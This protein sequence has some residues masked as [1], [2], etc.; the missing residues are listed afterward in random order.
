MKWLNAAPIA[1]NPYSPDILERRL[2]ETHNR[3]KVIDIHALM[4]QHEQPPS[5]EEEDSKNESDITP[6]KPNIIKYVYVD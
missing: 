6:Q 2:S 3:S 4:H 5:L 1:N